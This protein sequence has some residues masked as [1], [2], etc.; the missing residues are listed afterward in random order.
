VTGEHQRAVPSIPI[1]T[2]Y[3][4]LHV[5]LGEDYRKLGN[6][7]KAREHLAQASRSLDHV[8]G[9]VGMGPEDGYA[10]LVRGRLERLADLLDGKIT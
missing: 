1:E 4:S 3:P 5:N 8:G 7:V 10:K 6:P 9:M 2:V